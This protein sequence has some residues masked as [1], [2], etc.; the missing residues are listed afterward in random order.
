[1]PPEQ[2]QIDESPI[3]DDID[4]NYD[5]KCPRCGHSPT[6]G[7]QCTALYCDDG[8]VDLYEDDPLMYD[9]GEGESC[10]E[11]RG[12]GYVQW[13]PGCGADLTGVNVAD[14]A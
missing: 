1:M 8:W 7:R 11:C 10:D 6:R 14:Q 4:V 2:L 12:H 5:G 9:P 3:D 13:C